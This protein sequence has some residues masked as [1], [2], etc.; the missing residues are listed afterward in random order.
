MDSGVSTYSPNN[1]IYGQR[2]EDIKRLNEKNR[3]L[4]KELNY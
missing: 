4:N 1:T 2:A 3:K